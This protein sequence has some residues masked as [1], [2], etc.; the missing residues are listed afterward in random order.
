MPHLLLLS[1]T[2]EE[3]PPSSSLNGSENGH[4]TKTPPSSIHTPQS[5]VH[6]SRHTT[7]P[8]LIDLA[9]GLQYA[10]VEGHAPL[11][12]FAR[13]FIIRTHKPNYDD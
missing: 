1:S 7:D 13:D 11:L 12:Q 5:T 4:Q 10:A 9:R 6:I 3:E 8:K 2:A